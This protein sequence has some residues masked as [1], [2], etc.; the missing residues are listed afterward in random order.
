[1]SLIQRTLKLALATLLAIY[2]A[3]QLGLLY[4]T[5]AGIV[6]LLS[7][8]ETRRSSFR[9][10]GQRLLATCL[11][12]SLGYL[13]FACFGFHLWGLGLYLLLFIPLS[14]RWGLEAG[15]APSTV[16]VTHLYLEKSLAVGLLGNELALFAIGVGMALFFNSYMSSK[17]DMIEAYH[18]R[19]ENILKDIMLR[20]SHL[21]M[22]GDGAN[23]GTLIQQL[24][25]ILQ[26]A[27]QVVYLERHNQVFKTTDYHVH[28]FS[29]RADQNKVLRQMAEIIKRLALKTPESIIL[30]QLF[31][32]VANEISQDNSGLE[33]LKA[34]DDFL[35][36]FRQR[37]LPKTRQEFENR[38]ILFQ[39]LNDMKLFIQMKVDFYCHYQKAD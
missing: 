33:Q 39:L 20:F 27:E 35:I 38:A 7:V 19:V 26:E 28:Y 21:L 10:A 6:A 17:Q 29:M 12:L 37:D 11:A 31:Q 5:S 9:L 2:L 15:L 34:I 22:E 24:D 16:L 1:M 13:I 32:E 8:L 36:T 25:L 30:A 3:E 23:D 4:A 18:V 14:Y